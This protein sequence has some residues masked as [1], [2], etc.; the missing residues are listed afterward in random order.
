MASRDHTLPPPSATSNSEA[1][2]ALAAALPFLV[3]AVVYLVAML[4]G[5][6]LLT[7]PDCYW[8]VAVGR[9]IVE[10][11]AVPTT[12]PFSFTFAGAHWI[13]K[14]WLSQLL[15]YGAYQ[16]AG[17]TG[18]AVIAAAAA[19]LAFGLLAHQLEKTL[20]PVAVLLLIA[21]A[22]VLVTPHLTARPHALALPVMVAW[23]AGLV[24]AVDRRRAPSLWLL[25]LMVLWANLHGGF[26]LGFVLVGATGLDAVW[27]ASAAER[28]SLAF[29][30][31]RFGILTLVAACITPYGPESILVTGRIL[32]MGGTLH[33]ITEWR[34]QDFGH[35][36]PFEILLLLGIGFSLWRGL[37][38]PPARI[39]TIL[40]L[41]HL[42]LSAE[43]NNEL[44]G[45][46]VPLF[47][48]APLAAQFP[49][50]RSAPGRN[51]GARPM[52]VA[53]ILAALVPATAGA[54][55]LIAMRPPAVI[56][57]S[58]ALAALR[59]ATNGPVFN[60]YDFGGYLI[61]SG[62]PTFIDGR[63]ELYGADFVQRYGAAVTLADPALLETLLAEHHVA[64]TLLQAGMPAIA[65][66]DRMPGWQ[67]L[68]AD[69]VGVVHIRTTAP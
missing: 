51:A 23:T 54:A 68:Y 13:A 59:A 65:W 30:W 33:F 12:D 3:A 24:A 31:I 7:D 50:A 49:S 36:A 6:N 10:H 16:L 47:L 11:G 4:A 25:P 62:V 66:L 60:A 55:A 64:A 17:W 42:A 26:T 67:R 40:G 38:L 28:K 5:A 46:L 63:T 1:A 39:L 56:T 45:L 58:A 2:P 53:A 22:F 8:H 18:M 57:P 20:A 43:R 52:L 44:V 41:V 27:S 32:G 15:Y 9:W 69:D 21:A 34:P 35:L 29:T 48:A 14:E 19:A 37:T 61:A